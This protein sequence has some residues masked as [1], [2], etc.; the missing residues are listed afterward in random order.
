[1]NLITPPRAFSESENRVL[2]QLP[3]ISF[4]GLFSGQFVS[5]FEKYI[6]DQFV[7]R[8]AWIG[9]KSNADRALGKKE[10]NGV[11]LGKDQHLIQKSAPLS[12]PDLNQKAQAIHSFDNQTPD[13]NKVVMLVPTAVSVLTDK[14]PKY[15]PNNDEL[16]AIRYLD[17]ILHERISFTDVYKLFASKK[18]E[19]LYYK[20]DHHWTTKGAY[21]AYQVLGDQLGYTPLDED[22]FNVHQVANDFYGSLYSK[23]GFRHLQPDSIELYEPKSAQ[24]V[25]VAYVEENQSSDTFYAKEQLAK[26]DKYAVFFNGNHSLV[27]ITSTSSASRKLLVVKDSYAN[28]LVPFL[29]AHFNEIYMIDLR[30]YGDDVAN[31]VQ[32]HGIDNMLLLYN[33]HTFM[34][35]SSILNLAQ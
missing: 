6:S 13:L 18:D 19:A 5:T 17:G 11:Y 33:I 2:E 10:S 9:V 29:A 34:E 14:L 8:D 31:F 35:D 12:I 3:S 22:K 15:A 25:Q 26:K 1:M 27:K 32:D 28:S 21:Y 20:T 4:H 16:Q 30:Y 23:S 7:A 24:S